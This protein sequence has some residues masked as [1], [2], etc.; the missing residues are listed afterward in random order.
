MFGDR[1][2]G[3]RPQL[4]GKPVAGID[5][6]NLAQPLL[7]HLHQV[8]GKGV[9][10]FIGEDAAAQA[11]QFRLGAP[12]DATGGDMFFQAL[13]LPG[14]VVGADLHHA[15]I[16]IFVGLGR[17]LGDGIEDIEGQVSLSRSLLG[18]G[19]GAPAEELPHLDQL[20]GDQTPEQGMDAA[21]GEEIPALADP[22]AGPGVVAVIGM[23][24]AGIHVV[25]KRDAPLGVDALT[26]EFDELRFFGRVVCVGHDQC[27]RWTT[28]PPCLQTK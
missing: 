14:P 5:D 20:P 11:G 22:L 13:F 1:R 21:R 6:E 9:N 7:R 16:E 17:L 15:V 26:Q 18:N 12:G 28:R 24:E 23:I 2:V 4:L 27:F 3:E 19:E 10:Q 25:G 8:D